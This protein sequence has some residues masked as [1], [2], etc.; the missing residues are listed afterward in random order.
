MSIDLASLE[1]A[2]V[3]GLAFG[4]VYALLALGFNLVVAACGVFSLAQSA[5]ISGGVV[6]YFVFGQQAGVPY[7][8]VL[9]GLILGGAAINAAVELIA[10]RRFLRDARSLSHE[11]FVSTLAS[12]LALTSLVAL[13]FG[14][15]QY[16]TAS[17]VSSDPVDLLGLNVRP[18]FL[19]I[20][21][22]TATV[23]VLLELVLR[24]TEMGLVMRAVV[25]DKEGAELF[26][27]NVARV[28]QGAFI[29]SGAL[30]GV[31]AFLI[32]P[33]LQA[34]AFVGDQIQI[35]GIA[36]VAIGGFASFRGAFVGG[37]L[38]GLIHGVTP[39]FFEATWATPLVYLLLLTVLLIKP[40]GIFGRS[41]LFGAA[42]GRQV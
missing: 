29:A 30:V 20:F 25:A 1:V 3:S 16:P 37:L 28:V 33:L 13:V 31:A 23:A 39:L 11:T 34:S 8:V 40:A 19:V 9:V 27:I 12:S 41:G 24:H 4:C 21:A 36:A 32:A 5:I 7:L 18:L 14:G 22:T 42:E 10:V 6:A 17:F 35:Y 38:V 26:G 2:I 15:E